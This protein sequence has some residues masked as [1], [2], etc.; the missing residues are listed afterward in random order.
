MQV[1]ATGPTVTKGAETQEVARLRAELQERDRKL[2]E[3]NDSVEKI[4]KAQ[5]QKNADEEDSRKKEGSRQD[6]VDARPVDAGLSQSQA[7]AP[8]P[9]TVTGLGQSQTCVEHVPLLPLSPVFENER[10]VSRGLRRKDL[11]RRRRR[12]P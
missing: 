5:L 4:I 6:K 3:L 8:E 11:R 9:E 12:K 2:A 7:D 1:A 10:P